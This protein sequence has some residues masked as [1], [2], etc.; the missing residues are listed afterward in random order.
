MSLLPMLMRFKPWSGAKGASYKQLWSAGVVVE[1]LLVVAVV[2]TSDQL[3]A[4][5]TP[6][7]KRQL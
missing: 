7:S 6:I 5:T 4:T 2:A 3:L 1:V